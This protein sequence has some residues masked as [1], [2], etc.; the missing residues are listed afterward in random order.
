MLSRNILF[1]GL[2]WTVWGPPVSFIVFVPLLSPRAGPS[3]CPLGAVVSRVVLPRLGC[4]CTCC[5]APPVGLASCSALGLGVRRAAGCVF[6][7]GP[8]AF[9]SVLHLSLLRRLGSVRVVSAARPTTG[10]APRGAPW[11]AAAPLGHEAGST[12][13]ALGAIPQPRSRFLEGTPAPSFRG[14]AGSLLLAARSPVGDISPEG[15]TGRGPR[16]W[17]PLLGFGSSAP[18]AIAV[19]GPLL[20]AGHCCGVHFSCTRQ[21]LARPGAR[22]FEWNPKREPLFGRTSRDTDPSVPI[23]AYLHWRYALSPGSVRRTPPPRE[24]AHSPSPSTS[25]PRSWQVRRAAGE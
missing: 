13:A 9:A 12:L 14:A 19:A 23:P 25:P 10:L 2:H 24:L 7:P 1:R 11:C 20:G 4:V 5:S 21:R 6:S 15:V 3:V 16:P 17:D 18:T 22:R 8:M